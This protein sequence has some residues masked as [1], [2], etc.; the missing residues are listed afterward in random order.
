MYERMGDS[1]GRE[2]C[3]RDSSERETRNNDRCK[4]DSCVRNRCGG[5]PCGTVVPGTRVK[6]VL[7]LPNSL[8]IP[9]PHP[10]LGRTYG[11]VCSFV[12]LH[13]YH[14]SVTLHDSA[15]MSVLTLMYP[16]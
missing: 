8:C 16:S 2:L 5:G 7:L 12:C 10:L 6:G 9:Y 1:S 14:D 13:H 15:S 11:L 4:T 3:K